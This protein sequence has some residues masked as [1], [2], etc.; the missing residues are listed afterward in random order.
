[1]EQEN[2]QKA[3]KENGL[4]KPNF[5]QHHFFKMKNIR[6][7]IHV[8]V[9]KTTTGFSACTEREA[10]FTTADH[11]AEL[12]VHLIEGLNLFYEEE[13]YVTKENLK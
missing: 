4:N 12:Y 11:T 7:K 2:E 10:V 3:Y 1:M 13:V 8:K 5:N 9:E 6:K